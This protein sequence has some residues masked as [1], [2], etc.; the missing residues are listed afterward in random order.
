M[1]RLDLNPL[2]R[3]IDLPGGQRSAKHVGLGEGPMS[4]LTTE[5]AAAH[6][7][8][9]DVV[10]KELGGRDALL[11]T[12]SVAGETQECQQLVVLLLDP[13]YK[14][15]SLKR[16]CIQANLTVLDLFNAYKQALVVRAHLAAYK[17]ITDKLLPVV[18]DVM[19]RAAPYT[20]PCG[21]CGATGQ[22]TEGKEVVTCPACHGHKA[23]IVHPDLDRQ[24]LALELAQLVQKSAGITVQQTNV[25]PSSG[26]PL[27]T[28]T[29]LVDLQRA[30]REV[31]RGP[32]TPLVL[33]QAPADPGPPS[34]PVPP[35]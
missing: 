6:D 11:D 33:D 35:L 9:L 19:Q 12:L 17:V 1:P 8:A 18:E 31:L 23:L 2:S 20:V 15:W 14:T 4:A 30:V 25:T 5:E 29:T 28:S 22:V 7:Q 10:I 13:R 26:P 32:R 27:G 34:D 16:L 21:E 24:K 3:I